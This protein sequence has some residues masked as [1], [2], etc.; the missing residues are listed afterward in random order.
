[1]EV[2][3]EAVEAIAPVV[4]QALAK[5]GVMEHVSLLVEVTIKNVY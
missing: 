1:M 4:A 2:A 5:V 3:K